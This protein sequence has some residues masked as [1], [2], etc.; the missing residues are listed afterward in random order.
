MDAPRRFASP[1]SDGA[2]SGGAWGPSLYYLAI[3]LGIVAGGIAFWLMPFPSSGGRD[4]VAASP[5][6]PSSAAP[7]GARPRCGRRQQLGARDAG[8]HGGCEAQRRCRCAGG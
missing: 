4:S 6:V 2:G 3:A 5:A 7:V 1:P 8:A